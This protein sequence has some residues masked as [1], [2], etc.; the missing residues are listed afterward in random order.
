M[1]G[2]WAVS[3]VG[4]GPAASQAV[5][6]RVFT[7][8]GEPDELVV[9]D[10]VCF[11]AVEAL[12]AQGGVGESTDDGFVLGNGGQGGRSVA[13]VAVFPGDVLEVRVGERGA[14]GGGATY[15]GGG[16]GTQSGPAAGG[17]GGGASDVRRDGEVLVLAGG[18]GGGTAA[19]EGGA[20]GGTEGGA[21]GPN[22][23]GGAGGTQSAGGADGRGEDGFAG[24]GG[25]LFGGAA[26]T[27]A[28][29][30]GG[31][32]GWVPEGGTTEAGVRSGHGQVTISW[33]SDHACPDPDTSSQ[34]IDRPPPTARVEGAEVTNPNAPAAQLPA[35][36]ADRGVVAAL[37][38]LGAGLLA[39][40][41]SSGASRA[42]SPPGT[43]PRR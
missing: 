37:S 33:G 43:P 14:T 4:A 19:G 10:G 25:G 38:L 35:T 11:V 13:V 42:A 27:T 23:L 5:D 1:V 36:G 15:N 9:P 21:G 20:G 24:G 32:S 31:G 17:S 30:A 22:G 28:G 39:G 18:G 16:A 2:S 3:V 6:E 41:L 12:G 26:S 40:G 29:G 7:F 34:T 8:T